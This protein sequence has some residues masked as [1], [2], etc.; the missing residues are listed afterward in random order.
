[1]IGGERSVTPCT[2]AASS[3][4]LRRFRPHSS[5]PHAVHAILANAHSL[6]SDAR[7]SGL[8]ST[9]SGSQP[10]VDDRQMYESQLQNVLRDS[11]PSRENA[12]LDGISFGSFQQINRCCDVVL[13]FFEIFFFF[14][15]SN[16]WSML[17]YSAFCSRWDTLLLKRILYRLRE[18][19]RSRYNDCNKFRRFDIL[20]ETLCLLRFSFRRL[21]D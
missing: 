4:R 17:S 1:M 18:T 16:R 14:F 6:A 20:R 21:W 15:A 5:L 2:A 13:L 7:H 12:F 19:V 10:F 8:R 9:G 11:L 3:P